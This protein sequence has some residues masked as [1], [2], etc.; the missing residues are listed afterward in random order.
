M[1]TSAPTSGLARRRSGSRPSSSCGGRCTAMQRLADDFKEFL[2]L[3]RDHEVAYLLI[4]GYA[5]GYHGHPRATGDMDIWVER[6]ADNAARL[7]RVLESFGFAPGT[8]RESMFTTAGKIVRMGVPPLRLE[9]LNEIDGVEF[10]DCHARRVEV[11]IDGVVVD[12][13]SLPDLRLNKAASGRLK[14]LADLEQ[15]PE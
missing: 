7:V 6:S 1:T 8:V 4:G 13:I 15:L 2:R 12:L 3:L 14:D 11:S 9:I 10:E 5:V